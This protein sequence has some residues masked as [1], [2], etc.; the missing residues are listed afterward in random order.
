V[1]A[2]EPELRARTLFED[3]LVGV[4]RAEHPLAAGEITA[5]RY[6]AGEHVN[7]SRRVVA[8]VDDFASALAIARGSD[9]V[10]TV[11]ERHTGV[12]RVGMH[13][14]P[15]P[16]ATPRFTVSLLWHPWPHADPAHRWLRGIVLEV[17]RTTR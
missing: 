13:T 10:A 6:A 12:P 3:R 5:A 2:G 9:L 14:F 7:V 8:I 4:V 16:V 11:P 17:C 15:L 1:R